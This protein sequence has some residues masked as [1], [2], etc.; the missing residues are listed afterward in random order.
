MH[1][2]RLGSALV[3]TCQLVL[4]AV[5]GH[6]AGF[7]AWQQ[8]A[9]SV[10][11]CRAACV[12]SSG[13]LVRYVVRTHS[14]SR[15]SCMPRARMRIDAASDLVHGVRRSVSEALGADFGDLFRSVQI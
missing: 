4:A 13:G 10:P 6:D 15:A 1:E 9:A 7:W 3:I 11:A 8:V 12:S 5:D 14:S 2:R